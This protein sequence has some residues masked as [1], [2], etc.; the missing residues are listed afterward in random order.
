M[1]LAL[2][3]GRSAVLT[4]WL[5][6]CLA[7][8]AC[9]ANNFNSA[10]LSEFLAENQK[11]FKDNDGDF[12]PWIELHNGG[13][14]TVNLD[15]WFLTDTPTNRCRWRLPRVLLLPDRY[16]IVFASGKA[17]SNDLAHLHTNFRPDR[18]GGYLAL[19]DPATNVVSEFAPDPAPQRA[20]VSYGRIRGEPAVCGWFVQPS[21]GRPNAS[22]GE[23]FAPEVSFSSA[24]G[25][26]AAPFILEIS[27]RAPS[28]VIHY[29]LNGNLPNRQSPV[30]REPLS[31]TN[32]VQVR[33]RAYQEDLLP[34]PPRG[35][36]FLL[37]HSNVV[38]FTSTLPV[39]VMQ[40]FG[41]DQRASSR[42]GSVHLS[43]FEPVHGVTS[44]TNPPTLTTRGGFH[45]RGSSSGDMPQPGFAV[46]CLDEFDGEQPRPVLGLPADSDWVL[47]APNGY[48]PGMIHNPFVHQLS[49]DM[50][51]YSPRTR[52]LEVYV[53]RQAGPVTRTHYHGV[54]VL[55]EKIKVGK[56]RLNIDR[57]GPEDL[58]PPQVTGGYLLK[59]DRLGPGEA[60]FGGAGASMVYVEPKEPVI[61][62]PQRAPQR[63]Y[64]DSYF[65]DFDRALNG[66]HWKDPVQGY[67]AYVD[68]EAW[69]DYHVLEVLSGNVDALNLSTYLHKPR[70]GNLAFGPHWD[71]DRALGSTDDRDR[72]P[73]QWNTGQFFSGAWWP[74]LF[75]DPD[76]WQRWVDRW[77]ELRLTHFSLTNLFGLTDRLGNE[78]R[79][80]HPREVKR[81]GLEPRGGSYESE[82]NHMKQWLSNRVDFIDHELVQPPRFQRE[83]GR[84]PAGFLLTLAAPT[85]ATVYCTLDGSDPRLS[86]G[87]ISSNAMVYSNAIPLLTNI[88]IVARARNSKQRQHGGPPISTPWSS[89][90][91]AKFTVT[92]P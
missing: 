64:L 59:I 20:D 33:A 72:D 6:L 50:G 82:L 36:S 1:I 46:E 38:A 41:Q 4:G 14:S 13:N 10:Y 23:G 81:W 51:R 80:A 24:S 31:I 2:N 26:F 58:Q 86:Q 71:F 70:L 15:G 87:A 52:F 42:Y 57:L 48:D 28:A 43:F 54:Y 91:R 53:V 85:N 18:Q 75:S 63:Q 8:P 17:R 76:F 90:V 35:E 3:A 78:V 65:R 11:G 40:T 30:Y 60:G 25:T 79:E 77:Q 61:L 56:R 32:T 69:I 67:R 27:A 89:P 88:A 5:L 34:G 62:L 9:A 37:L 45:Q 29:T 92:P 74:R 44:L 21:P 7:R 83:G 39:L 73:R 66:P 49:R 22:R 12:S 47:Y 68:V 84:I 16:L 19:V 55:E